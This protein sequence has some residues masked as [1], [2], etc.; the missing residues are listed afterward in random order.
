[1][2]Y[3]LLWE[4]NSPN[5]LLRKVEV[6]QATAGIWQQAARA[7]PAAGAA[8]LAAASSSGS[9]VGAPILALYSRGSVLLSSG[10]MD[11]NYI[12]L[13]NSHKCEPVERCLTQTY[14]PAY[15]FAAVSWQEG[16]PPP[17]EVVP[18][19]MPSAEFAGWRLLSGHETGQLLLWHVQGLSTRY[20]MRAIQLL[21]VILEPKQLRWVGTLNGKPLQGCRAASMTWLQSCRF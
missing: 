14:G 19:A 6:P 17:Q 21:S 1:M 12:T 4:R 16:L 3:T 7:G 8:A 18:G 11:R 2:I 9:P 15:S 20:G 5:L 13:W 10:G